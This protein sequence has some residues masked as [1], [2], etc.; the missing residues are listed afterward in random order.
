MAKSRGL[1]SRYMKYAVAL[2]WLLVY[3]F[4]FEYVLVAGPV[5][6]LAWFIYKNERTLLVGAVALLT[7]LVYWNGPYLS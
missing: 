2:A 1:P 7:Y 6:V 4:G 5:F 3:V